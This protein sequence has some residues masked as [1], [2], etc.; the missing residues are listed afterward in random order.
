MMK[1]WPD[2]WV[3]PPEQRGWFTKCVHNPLLY[4]ILAVILFTA[5]SICQLLW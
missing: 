1:L 2:H 4:V 5:D 3:T